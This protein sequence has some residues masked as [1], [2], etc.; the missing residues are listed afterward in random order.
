MGVS[1]GGFQKYEAKAGKF[2]QGPFSVF[3]EE[4]G[5]VGAYLTFLRVRIIL[6]NC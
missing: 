6:R 3:G 4:E 2:L 5:V 1:L